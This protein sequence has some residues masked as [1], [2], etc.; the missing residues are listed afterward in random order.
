VREIPG[1]ILTKIDVRSDARGDLWKLLQ[2]GAG[3]NFKFGESYLTVTDPGRWRAGHYHGATREWFI[4]VSGEA[5]FR[6][7]NL[8]TQDSVEATISERDRLR[9]EVS[10]RVAHAFKNVGTAPLLVLAVADRDYDPAHPD[11]FPDTKVA[12]EEQ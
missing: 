1:I 3:G 2:A 8:D 6:F 7:Y 12:F 11:T 4:V 5:L 9:M 10:P